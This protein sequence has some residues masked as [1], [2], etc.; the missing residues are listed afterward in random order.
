MKTYS[1][2]ETAKLLGVHRQTMINWIRK[3][4][5][6]PKRDYRRYPVFTVLDIESMIEW[7]NTIKFSAVSKKEKINSTL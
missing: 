1:M 5:V 3:G 4:W 2:T 6:R 7:K